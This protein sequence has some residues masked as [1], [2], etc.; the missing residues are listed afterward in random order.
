M[1]RREVASGILNAWRYV[2][3]LT[4]GETI[5]D[6][7]PLA[8]NDEFRNVSLR[9]DAPYVNVYLCGLRLNHYNFLLKD[10]SYFQ[11]SWAVEEEVRYAYYPNPFIVGRDAQRGKVARWHELLEADL[12]T[13]EEYLSIV[14]ESK[15]DVRI[16]VIRYENA[17]S[18]YISL[19]H[20]C[21]H[22]HVGHH[23]ENRWAVRRVLT[24]VAFALWI[25]KLYYSNEWDSFWKSE[26]DTRVNK[27]ELALKR[28]K[29]NC[30]VV[31]DQLFSKDE[32]DSFYLA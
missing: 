8:V 10:Y 15:P 6:P 5:S 18:Q 25:A 27:F 19:S 1:Q 20:P 23:P 29:N 30:A 31:A 11:F 16:P 26:N 2:D 12:I 9:E 7:S 17:P 4:I 14:R 22:L 24:P 21:S 13:F 3:E 28:E 32:I